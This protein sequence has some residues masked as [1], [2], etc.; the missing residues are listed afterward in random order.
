MGSLPRLT[1]L[2]L[3]AQGRASTCGALLLLVACG[4][5]EGG[6][7]GSLAGLGIDDGASAGQSQ[8]AL[9]TADAPATIKLDTGA[10]LS[11]PEGSVTEDVEVELKRPTDRNSLSLLKRVQPEFKVASAP[12][13]VTP[14]G[15]TFEKDLELTLPI[16]KGK[17]DRLVV[18]RLDDE[19]DSTWEVH[20]TPKISEG[21]AK[22]PVRH[23]SVYVLLEV[24]EGELPLPGEELL[25]GGLIEPADGGVSGAVDGM[26]ISMLP[27]SDLHE[28]VKARL[29]QCGLVAVPGAYDE[30][31]G[32]LDQ[33]AMCSVA[34]LFDAACAD[35]EAE[36][37]LGLS[38]SDALQT[39]FTKCDAFS[40]VECMTAF[41][42]LQIVA[43][44]DGHSQCVDGQDE[45]NCPSEAFLACT[46][47]SGER[48]PVSEKCNGWESCSDGSDEDGC[49]PGVHFVCETGGERVSSHVRCDGYSDCGDASDEANCE[50]FSCADG[51]QRVPRKLVCDL[52]RDCSDGSDEDQACLKLTCDPKANG[53]SGADATQR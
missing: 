48:V 46:G 8:S 38:I 43:S 19:E 14:H 41:N 21:A 53:S 18:A 17:T 5:S 26:V 47:F 6:S 52:S 33:R 44:C 16:A 2:R 50:L 25:D 12:Y 30:D 22:I 11:I 37:C 35:W 45:A 42:G 51:A 13:V 15:T 3:R 23:F 39:C 7:A 24:L 34:C 40:I 4:G 49:A 36:F 27:P 31:F 1:S 28:R 9:I 32:P 10:R 20:S 29:A